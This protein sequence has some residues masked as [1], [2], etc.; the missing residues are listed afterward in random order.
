MLVPC[1]DITAQPRYAVNRDCTLWPSYKGANDWKICSLVP[2]ME[3]D[4]KVAQESLHC[5]LNTLEA[6]MS[7]IM[8]KGKVCEVGTTD[9]AAMGYYLVKLLTE[10]YTL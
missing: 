9:K 1:G 3:A 2:K 8:H 5:I 6:C 10:P 7:F 4:K